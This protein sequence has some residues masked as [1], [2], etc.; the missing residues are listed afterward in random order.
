MS[1][2]EKRIIVSIITGVFIL[3]A[4]CTYVFGKYQSGAIAADDLK[5]WAGAMLMFIGIGIAAAVAIQIIF[6][7]LLSVAIA[8]QEKVKNGQCDD[9]EIE[10]TIG[11]EIVTD[12][13]DKLIELKS[14]RIGFSVAGI[15]FVAA[16]VSLILNY[17]PA[18]MINIMFVSFSAGSLLEGFTKLYFYRKGVENG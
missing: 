9:K 8:V 12:E 5:F 15:G 3:G 13:M 2:Q 11:A 7:I 17:S 6:H 1:Y 16:L 4:Y 14:M 18:V 10:K